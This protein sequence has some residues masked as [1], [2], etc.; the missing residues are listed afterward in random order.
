MT[1]TFVLLLGALVFNMMAQALLKASVSEVTFDSQLMES[2]WLVLQN[3]RVWIGGLCYVGSFMLYVVALSR[4]DLGRIGLLSQAL[5][6][7]GLLFLSTMV[8]R[9]PLTAA[10]LTG[11]VLL[12]IGIGFL[13]RG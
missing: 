13:A 7:F 2:L 12:L 6:V 3:P 9:E 4:G 11:A 8:F 1:I 5:T 10:R